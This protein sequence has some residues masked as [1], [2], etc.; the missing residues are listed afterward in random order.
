MA[1][2]AIF[3]LHDFS[4]GPGVRHRPVNWK[5]RGRGRSETAPS[6]TRRTTESATPHAAG[7]RPK[8]RPESP[9][10]HKLP[11]A[12]GGGGG[13]PLATDVDTPVTHH[14]LE[15]STARRSNT[16]P[17]SRK[18]R[19]KNSGET[20]GGAHLLL[21]LHARSCRARRKRPLT[22]A[23]N[24]G[25]GSASI[26]VHMGAM[27][28]RKAVLTEHGDMPP[29]PFGLIDNPRSWPRTKPIW[30]SSIRSAPAIAE[31]KL[32]TWRDG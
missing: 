29:P 11:R 15:I 4:L 23:F 13:P 24:G 2:V 19:S 18:C 10:V 16:P 9:N 28:P 12:R 32:P 21:R 7:R 22:F 31:R 5:R 17:P 25:P 3:F 1:T 30:C 6:E 20:E 26:W 27:G 14:K 8:R